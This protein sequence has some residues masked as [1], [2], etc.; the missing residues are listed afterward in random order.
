MLNLDMPSW[1]PYLF[2]KIIKLELIKLILRD[3]ARRESKLNINGNVMEA[4]NP[5]KQMYDYYIKQS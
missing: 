5:T 1:L 3:K 4:V 2:N